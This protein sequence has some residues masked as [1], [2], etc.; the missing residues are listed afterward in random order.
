MQMLCQSG[1]RENDFPPADG[2]RRCARQLYA[3]QKRII[4]SKDADSIQEKERSDDMN[5]KGAGLVLTV[6]LSMAAAFPVFAMETID[7]L[8]LD[9]WAGFSVGSSST[10]ISVGV[11]EDGCYVDDM[12]VTNASGEWEASDRPKVCLTVMADE[13]YEFN[14]DF[15]KDDVEIVDGYGTVTSV[16]RSGNQTLKVYV[17][18]RRVDQ[19]NDKYSE[20]DDDYSD[21]TSSD[22]DYDDSYDD[23]EDYD[24]DYDDE[25]YD[26]EDSYDDGDYDLE[27]GEPV[28]DDQEDGM[29][30]WDESDDARRY[31]LRL[32]LDDELYV[33]DLSSEEGSYDFSQFIDQGGSYYFEVRAVRGSARGSW[34]TSDALDV[35]DSQ[36]E[37][38]YEN[39]YRSENTYYDDNSGPG[40]TEASPSTVSPT[41]GAWLKDDIGYWWCNPDKTYPVSAW[42]QIGG[43]WYYF[44]ESGYCVENAW[45]LTNE[46]YYYCGS[47]GA[48]LTNTTTPDGYYVDSDGV[49]IS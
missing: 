8:T 7:Y 23:E 49:W 36:A 39:R 15:S 32:Y 47:D 1:G 40:A 17:T 2:V 31:Q 21:K 13:E 11:Q 42:K 37:E 33:S 41:E 3:G 45:V 20:E 43:Q 30:Y 25:D 48:M 16:S 18:L 46:K 5:K 4:L 35:S 6:L 22:E 19:L 29:A 38:I 28:W 9:I 34:Y 26:D 14:S 27:A 24:E 12:E 44:N 10:D